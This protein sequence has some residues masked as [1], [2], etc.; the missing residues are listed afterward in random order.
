MKIL[1]YLKSHN[2][3]TPV[4][5]DVCRLFE[6]LGLFFI[7]L[8]ILY[9][10]AGFRYGPCEPVSFKLFANRIIQLISRIAHLNFKIWLRAKFS[11]ANTIGTEYIIPALT[12]RQPKRSFSNHCSLCCSSVSKQNYVVQCLKGIFYSNLI[13]I[14]AWSVGLR[15]NDITE[16]YW[17]IPQFD[18]LQPWSVVSLTYLCSF[19]FFICLRKM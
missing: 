18:E 9:I 14:G 8:W 4:Y 7:W 11:Q 19:I 16:R 10:K 3:F 17:K 5:K 12:V 13:Y 6:A 2:L 15:N 1:V